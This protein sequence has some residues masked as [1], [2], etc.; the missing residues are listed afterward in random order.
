VSWS[1][2]K[3]FVLPFGAPETK[4]GPRPFAVGFALVPVAGG[5]SHATYTTSLFQEG[6]RESSRLTVLGATLGFSFRPHSA[7][8]IGA[9][10]TGLYASL[11]QA[12]ITGG[13]GTESA[14]LVRNYQNGQLDAADP[15]FQL[16]GQNVTWGNVLSVAH[17]PNT[18]SSSRVTVEGATGVGIAGSL[19]V[20][21]QPIDE[22]SIGAAYRSPGFL[23]PL[24]GSAFLDSTQATSAGANGLNSIQGSFLANHLPDGGTHLASG[25]DAKLSGIKMPE[26]A[27]VGVAFWPHP[28]VLLALDL[29]WIDWRRA[30]DTITVEL[31]RGNSRDLAEITSNQTSGK[32]TSK[33]LYRWHEQLVVAAGFAVAP[34]DWLRL[35]AGYN[36]GND[37]VP[38]RTENPFNAATV[39]HHVTV[40]VGLAFDPVSFDVAW[41]HAFPKST[42]IYDNDQKPD[43][44][45]TR[46]KAD[47]DAVLLGGAVQF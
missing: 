47:Q 3:S 40:G 16:N 17:A 23:T 43:F 25:F 14:G 10:V 19:G 42:G 30:F 24:E 6:E 27:G 41:V 11:D 36:F 21:F 18:F 20:L 28:K 1:W 32:I 12:G 34:T 8:A 5:T 13:S 33:V 39:E 9:G 46:H 38:S 4:D 22:L 31:T 45:G 15:F 7:F 29:K 44:N 26:T 2:F 37:P 35:R